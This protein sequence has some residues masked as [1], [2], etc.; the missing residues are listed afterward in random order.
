MTRANKPTDVFKRINMHKGDENVCWEWTGSLNRSDGRPYY[1][2]SGH[3]R[4]A[5]SVVLELVSGDVGEGRIVLH[6]CDN[7]IC[8]NPNHLT[9]G[10]HQDNM[11]DMKERDRHGLPKVVIRAIL[12]LRA[13][14]R[15]QQDIA[16]LYG[17][18]REA[19]SAIETGRGKQP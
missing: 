2:V 17:V 6:S 4:L 1:T 11:N 18:S 12:R 8:C 14:G 10:T 13:E 15:S 3:R 16:D 19:I 5:Y 9:Y 7:P